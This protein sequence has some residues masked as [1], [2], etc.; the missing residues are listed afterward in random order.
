LAW[1]A[2][3]R[4]Q[5][6]PDELVQRILRVDRREPGYRP[7]APGDD[8]LSATRDALEMFA[9]PIVKLPHPDLVAALM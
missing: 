7:S 9:E 1:P 3:Q 8:D 4:D 5:A 2:R 6:S